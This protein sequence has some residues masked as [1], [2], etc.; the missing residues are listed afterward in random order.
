M[1]VVSRVRVSGPLAGYA[2]VFAA[3]LAG[4][5]YTPLS[6]ANQV[7]VLAHLSRWLE[8]RGFDPGELTGLRVQEFPGGAPRRGVYVLAV[9]AGAGAVAGLP[10]GPGRGA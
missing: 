10:A 6:A 3:Y 7:R 9:G 4:A 5:G 1:D 8:D 2:A